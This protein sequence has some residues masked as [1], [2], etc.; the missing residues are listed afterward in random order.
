MEDAVW[1]KW[2]RLYLLAKNTCR[3]AVIRPTLW[4]GGDVVKQR[5]ESLPDGCGVSLGDPGEIATD[6]VEIG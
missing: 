5:A 1:G 6:V 2:T 3:K 4:V